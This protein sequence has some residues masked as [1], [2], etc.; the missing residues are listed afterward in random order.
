MPSG[1]IMAEAVWS[2]RAVLGEGHDPFAEA[3][4]FLDTLFRRLL[5]P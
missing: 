4:E 5:A 3:G 2:G 1:P